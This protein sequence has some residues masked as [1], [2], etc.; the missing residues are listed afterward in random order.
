M[1]Q[2]GLVVGLRLRAFS[3][4]LRCFLSCS[5]SPA[6]PAPAASRPALRLLSLRRRQRLLSLGSRPALVARLLLRL[7]SLASGAPWAAPAAPATPAAAATGTMA[8]E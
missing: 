6:A 7:F 8:S 1:S 5:V 3:S 4:R 2:S